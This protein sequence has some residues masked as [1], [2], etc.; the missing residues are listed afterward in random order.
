MADLDFNA[1]ERLN[2]QKS[3]V[4]IYFTSLV[5]CTPLQA[6]FNVHNNHDKKIKFALHVKFI[7]N[8]R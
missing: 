3:F 6:M 8:M 1:T 4:S 5:I 7:V 2:K